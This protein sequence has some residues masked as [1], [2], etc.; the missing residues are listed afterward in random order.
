MEDKKN[1]GEK[2]GDGKG[3]SEEMKEERSQKRLREEKERAVGED[4]ESGKRKEREEKNRLDALKSITFRWR[5]QHQSSVVTS[6]HPSHASALLSSL[7]SP[8]GHKPRERGTCSHSQSLLSW[9]LPLWPHSIF[10]I[11]F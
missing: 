5:A 4:K 2:E 10:F 3:K 9:A 6:S 7:Q 11:P 8:S 1:R